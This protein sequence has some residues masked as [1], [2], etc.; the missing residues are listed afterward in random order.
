[1]I[2]GHAEITLT[3]QSFGARMIGESGE[4]RWPILRLGFFGECRSGGSDAKDVQR[5]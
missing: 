5:H 4:V 3:F 1:M 2:C